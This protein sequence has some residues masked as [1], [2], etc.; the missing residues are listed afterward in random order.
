[1]PGGFSGLAILRD[2]GTWVKANSLKIRHRLTHAPLRT[3]FDFSKAARP[4]LPVNAARAR[5]SPAHPSAPWKR[6]RQD[7]P[8][9]YRYGAHS[10]GLSVSK[11]HLPAGWDKVGN[12]RWQQKRGA[13]PSTMVYIHYKAVKYR[14]YVHKSY[15]GRTYPYVT[16]LA[17]SP[18]VG[19]LAPGPHQPRLPD[20]IIAIAMGLT[21]SPDILHKP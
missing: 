10:S 19:F 18:S 20:P 15:A 9:L 8:R 21:A 5:S 7:R 1:M 16:W 17:S 11:W 4:T 6:P 2:G 3:S 14:Q 13:G 12:M